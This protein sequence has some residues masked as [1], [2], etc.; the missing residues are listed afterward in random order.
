G[1]DNVRRDGGKR[2]VVI[3]REGHAAP[4]RT[5]CI[6]QAPRCQQHLGANIFRQPRSRVKEFPAP[7]PAV[8]P[9]GEAHRARRARALA[10]RADTPPRYRSGGPPR[11]R[12]QYC[13][14]ARLSAPARGLRV[15]GARGGLLLGPPLHT[16]PSAGLSSATP[17]QE[18]A[19]ML[20]ASTLAAIGNVVA[21]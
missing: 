8:I 19:P 6:D 15:R 16:A 14:I 5:A 3:G 18:T 21:L 17:P 1:R 4:P 20:P 9:G 7:A 2:I 10:G 11:L 13:W 12:N